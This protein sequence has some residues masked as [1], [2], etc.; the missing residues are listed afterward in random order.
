MYYGYQNSVSAFLP[1]VVQSGN[2]Q[3]LDFTELREVIGEGNFV[4]LE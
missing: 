4:F 2:F 1:I 3:Q